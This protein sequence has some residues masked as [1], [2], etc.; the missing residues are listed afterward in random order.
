MHADVNGESLL[1]HRIE[2]GMGSPAHNELGAPLVCVS[3]PR[4]PEIASDALGTVLAL[5]DGG[6]LAT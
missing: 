4:Y 3:E 6:C 5:A 1:R 2:L